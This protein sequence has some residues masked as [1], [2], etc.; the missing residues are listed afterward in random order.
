M[1]TER[2]KMATGAWYSC[3]DDELAALRAKAAHAVFTHNATHPDERGDIAPT[4]MSVLGGVGLFS[5][6]KFNSTA[7]MVSIYI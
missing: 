1:T 3:V 7:H 6:S 5:G 4:L 2:E